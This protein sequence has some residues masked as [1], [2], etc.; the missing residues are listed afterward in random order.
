ML[1]RGSKTVQS[2][3]CKLE[4]KIS[5]G[6][7]L[8]CVRGSFPMCPSFASCKYGIKVYSRA[9]AY[10]RSDVKKEGRGRWKLTTDPPPSSSRLISVELFLQL[11]SFLTKGTN[12]NK[13]GCVALTAP[14]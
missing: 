13:L 3:A 12:E 4:S 2:T 8:V 6:A 5:R 1:F 11:I 10:L 7:S 9:K 14:Q